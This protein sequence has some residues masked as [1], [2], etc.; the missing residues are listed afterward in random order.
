MRPSWLRPQSNPCNLG[1]RFL[2]LECNQSVQIVATTWCHVLPPLRVH[3]QDKLDHRSSSPL[4]NGR[5]ISNC[6]RSPVL[7]IDSCHPS[8]SAFALDWLENG[9]TSAHNLWKSNWNT[10]Q[11]N[12]S[13]PWLTY[14]MYTLNH[15]CHSKW[16][17]RSLSWRCDCHVFDS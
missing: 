2:P 14:V 6:V 11:H 15:C 16:L 9:K 12:N 5:H 1:P 4:Q 10:Q 3:S 13:S 8:L 17:P 7:S